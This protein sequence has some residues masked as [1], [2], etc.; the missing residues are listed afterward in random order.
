M[1]GEVKQSCAFEHCDAV[2]PLA[3]GFDA[4]R[5]MGLWFQVWHTK[6]APWSTSASCTKAF[7]TDLDDLGT[8]AVH[9]SRRSAY[10]GSD[11]LVSGQVKCPVESGAGQ[12]TI[13]FNQQPFSE[14]PNYQILDTDYENYSVVNSC[15]EG[16]QHVFILSRTQILADDLE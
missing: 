6:A 3:D 10:G 4:E 15:G 16:F 12:C 9:N 13:T 8:F 2:E 11:Q 5:Y 14:C 1:E 7:Y